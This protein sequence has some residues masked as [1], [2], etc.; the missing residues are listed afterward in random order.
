MTLA[1]LNV[2]Y[3]RIICLIDIS[4]RDKSAHF[5]VVEIFHFLLCETV[6]SFDSD[7]FEMCYQGSN[8]Q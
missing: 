7:L 2:V 3:F 8:L 6:L 1:V 4:R 5:I